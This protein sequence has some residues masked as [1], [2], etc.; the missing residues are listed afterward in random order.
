MMNFVKKNLNRVVFLS[1]LFL[2]PLVSF[3][4]LGNA[5]CNPASGKICNPIPNITTL[6]GFIK[7]L[8][9]GII[10]IGL[11]FLVLAIIYCG[12]LFVEAQ[13]NEEKL[14]KAKDAILW[15]LIGA[16]ILIGSWAIALL[17]T[18]TVTSIAK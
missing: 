18:E 3:A 15:T 1:F 7:A 11:P 9:E 4:D 10:K 13:G 17:I 16:A 14:T 5:G 12:F 2:A 6:Q 8:L